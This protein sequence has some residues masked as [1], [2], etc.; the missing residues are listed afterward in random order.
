M[1]LGQKEGVTYHA[2]KDAIERIFAS[3]LFWRRTRLSKKQSIPRGLHIINNIRE[4]EG[5]R[6]SKGLMQG[7]DEEWMDGW[8]ESCSYWGE[9]LLSFVWGWKRMLR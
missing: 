7:N 6:L 5:E 2:G 8:I 9:V 3:P 4:A 1:D